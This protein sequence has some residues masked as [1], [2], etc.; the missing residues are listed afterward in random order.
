MLVWLA[1]TCYAAAAP[2]VQD[3]SEWKWSDVLPAKELAALQD[4]KTTWNLD[5]DFNAS[6]T[7]P[8][9][10]V[11][12]SGPNYKA[13]YSGT[14]FLGYDLT[15]KA[16]AFMIN[17]AA[18]NLRGIIPS[19]VTN[20]TE[21]YAL[22]LYNNQLSGEIPSG[23]G[24][25]TKLSKLGLSGNQLTGAIPNSIGDLIQL[26]HL[27]LGNNQLDGLIPPSIVKL[28]KLEVLGLEINKLTG[29]IPPA[30]GS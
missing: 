6:F 8:L 29:P 4:M 20:L 10:G 27:F 17:L 9:T 23:I 16:V 24:N 21:L 26:D 7:T 28:T 22:D 2:R 25:L 15:D 30:S 13:I 18:R 3:V 11:W 1:L 19:S 12:F 5:W 14:D